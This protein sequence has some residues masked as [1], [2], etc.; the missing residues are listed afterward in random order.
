M[1]L[2][3]EGLP[4]EDP[5]TRTLRELDR[6]M[7]ERFKPDEPARA[8]LIPLLREYAN[9]SRTLYQRVMNLRADE[10]DRFDRLLEQ[11]GMETGLI[12]FE[13]PEPDETLAGDWNLMDAIG[14]LEQ[15]LIGRAE[16][17]ELLAARIASSQHVE[18]TDGERLALERRQVEHELARTRVRLRETREAYRTAHTR[19]LKGVKDPDE[20][21]RLMEECVDAGRR[22]RET[23]EAISRLE[24]Q[25]KGLEEK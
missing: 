1:T 6:I 18:L 9:L 5:D 23:Q 21:L 15:T 17:C 2:D 7:T 20:E 11:I 4:E 14:D 24:K 25:L 3:L 22:H 19:L 12:P 8:Q 10:I 13:P 16:D